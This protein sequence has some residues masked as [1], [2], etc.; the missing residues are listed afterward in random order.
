MITHHEENLSWIS[1]LQE[2]VCSLERLQRIIGSQMS[3]IVGETADDI[4]IDLSLREVKEDAKYGR[5]ISIN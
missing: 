2:K 4:S 3:Q 5:N 1:E